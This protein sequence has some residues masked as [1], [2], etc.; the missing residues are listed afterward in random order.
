MASYVNLPLQGDGDDVVSDAG[1]D[2]D[3]NRPSSAPPLFSLPKEGT[4]GSESFVRER[5][6]KR[7]ESGV[8]DIR[9][10]ADYPEFYKKNHHLFNLPPPFDPEYYHL[11][12]GKQPMDERHLVDDMFSSVRLHHSSL[13]LDEFR[14]R[15]LPL[16]PVCFFFYADALVQTSHIFVE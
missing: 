8:D 16:F 1:D 11:N 2:R 10:N 4:F 3:E 15:A 12:S 14:L 6:L 7:I 9:K 5:T 13:L